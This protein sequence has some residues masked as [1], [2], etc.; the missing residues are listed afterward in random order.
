MEQI[1]P[2]ETRPAEGTK[3]DARALNALLTIGLVL[4]LLGYI[5]ALLKIVLFKN[6]LGAGIQSIN[7][8]PLQFLADRNMVSTDVFLKN[9]LGNFALFIPLGILIPAL[10]RRPSFWEALLAGVV[11][12]LCFEAL[13]FAFSWGASDI[14]D[15]ILNTL[16]TLVGAAIYF[17][18]FLH[19]KKY[20]LAKGLSFLFLALFGIAG[21][22]SLWLY[23]PGTL[24]TVV[25]YAGQEQVAD[26]ESAGCDAEDR[27]LSFA[28]GTL[29]CR[30]QSYPVADGARL[31]TMRLTYQLSPNGNVQK[32][33]ATYAAA[34][35]DEIAALLDGD[36]HFVDL[37]LRDGAAYAAVFTV[38]PKD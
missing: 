1:Q 17:V 7:L 6:G 12:S 10:S 31:Y 11:V 5:A 35:V 33:I 15:L 4:I 20:L 18:L 14:D 22:L 27:A 26:L 23:S 9:V 25:E 8:R 36:G 37:W 28:D 16:G 32:T 34:T 2:N 30:E 3:K 19:K 29:V 13:Q 21:A 38:H 24:P